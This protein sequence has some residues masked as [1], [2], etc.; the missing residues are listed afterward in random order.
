M[1]FFTVGSLKIEDCE[2]YIFGIVTTQYDHPRYVK[3]VGLIFLH[4]CKEIEVQFPLFFY[5]QRTGNA[6]KR[7]SLTVL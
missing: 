7:R 5:K 4:V 6:K 1:Q 2:L 3:H